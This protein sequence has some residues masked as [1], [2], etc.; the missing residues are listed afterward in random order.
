MCPRAPQVA[1]LRHNLDQFTAPCHACRESLQLVLRSLEPPPPLEPSAAAAVTKAS[2]A[3]APLLQQQRCLGTALEYALT[4][5]EHASEAPRPFS[6]DAFLF[7][8]GTISFGVAMLPATHQ[9]NGADGRAALDI[10][11]L[12]A[13]GQRACRCS[14]RV[15][16]LCS[17]VER[18]GV[19]ELRSLLLPCGGT[20]HLE[21]EPAATTAGG[22]SARL[23]SHLRELVRRAHQRQRGTNGSLELYLSPGLALSQ[24]LG[25]AANVPAGVGN[26]A[27]STVCLLGGLDELTSISALIDVNDTLG[28]EVAQ[29]LSLY[30]LLSLSC[31]PSSLSLVLL[32]LHTLSASVSFGRG[33]FIAAHQCQCSLCTALAVRLP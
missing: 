18:F 19:R 7:T 4:V 29:V 20:L 33:S 10:A 17:G 9:G 30:F 22:A 16:L 13:L 25:A 26:G 15:H 23:S 5:A 28:G 21:R 24:I 14:T 32:S 12:D 31:A 3:R 6:C 11:V 1:L 8:T 2:H 27:G